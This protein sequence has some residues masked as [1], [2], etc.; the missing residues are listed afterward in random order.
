[1]TDTEKSLYEQVL[2]DHDYVV[3]LRRHFHRHPEL[4]KEEYETQGA[5][6]REL[7][8]L[9]ITHRRIAETGVYAEIEG[10]APCEGKPRCIVLRADIDALPIQQENP[11]S[12]GRRSATARSRSLKAAPST[13]P[14]GASASIWRPMSGWA[15]WC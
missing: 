4:A 1:M 13:G 8:K 3:Q 14:T 9:G 7:D 2:A 6:E 12:R 5:I 15:P 11:G 10:T